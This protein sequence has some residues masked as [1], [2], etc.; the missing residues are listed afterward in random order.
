M[1]RIYI[2][3]IALLTLISCSKDQKTEDLERQLPVENQLS[4]GIKVKLAM[5]ATYEISTNDDNLRGLNFNP[6]SE[7]GEI[8]AKIPGKTI[9][10]LGLFRSERESDPIT[11]QELEFERVG[12]EDSNRLKIETDI[13]LENIDDATGRKW[14][15]LG[16]IGGTWNKETKE[17]SFKSSA[18]QPITKDELG[19]LD[20]PAISKWVELPEM[21][22]EDGK[23]YL[24]YP[25][26][27]EDKI[28]YDKY[29]KTTFYTQG[30]LFRYKID[31]NA[32]NYDMS[33]K[34]LTISSTAMVFGTTY[35][36]DKANLEA[37]NTAPNE[38]NTN[39]LRYDLETPAEHKFFPK[40]NKTDNEY[41][42][43]LNLPEALNIN[44]KAQNDKYILFWAMPNETETSNYRTAIYLDTEV[45]GGNGALL[46]VNKAKTFM[47]FDDTGYT[48]EQTTPATNRLQLLPVFYSTHEGKTFADGKTL[49]LK[50]NK[51]IRPK[52]PIEYMA[53]YNIKSKQTYIFK[54]EK[55]THPWVDLWWLPEGLNFV[56]G[57]SNEMDNKHSISSYTDCIYKEG[58]EAVNNY[59]EYQ[60]YHTPS[61]Y[62]YSA[63]LPVL[64]KYD[65]KD[66]DIVL[67]LKDALEFEGKV[68][69]EVPLDN[70]INQSKMTVKAHNTGSEVSYTVHHLGTDDPTHSMMLACRYSL[71]S[72]PDPDVQRIDLLWYPR[73]RTV[74]AVGGEE[75]MQVTYYNDTKYPGTKNYLKIRVR[76]LNPRFFN[77]GSFEDIKSEEFWNNNSEDDIVR[78]LTPTYQFTFK[79]PS[80]D[81]T[82]P[83]SII[84]STST[85]EGGVY[86]VFIFSGEKETIGYY[87]RNDKVLTCIRLFADK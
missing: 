19:E 55:T 34:G 70:A 69:I 76:Y 45:S 56:R 42:V 38:R 31:E 15:F 29:T 50:T 14:Y 63:V 6:T 3:L 23:H 25:K 4:K 59:P 27:Y 11:Y 81:A 26:D 65:S 32:S 9:K 2:I 22:I 68:D 57:V 74:E 8:K 37:L 39:L 44:A 71:E 17:L 5:E 85:K 80:T 66:K 28:A 52:L 61:L 79:D 12:E 82:Y 1:N 83:S 40:T 36:L 62:E 54:T 16:I 7:G 18:S 13:T 87:K 35:K 10:V 78:Y 24:D 53:D 41:Q 43:K 67:K 47:G 48:S 60:G 20:V 73:R 72:N 75:K 33:I 84:M 77:F 86:K 58:I 49:A 30:M 46:D 21:K 64:G 51:I